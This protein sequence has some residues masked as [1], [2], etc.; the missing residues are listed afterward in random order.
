MRKS[1]FWK[2]FV[3]LQPLQPL[4]LVETRVEA[5]FSQS[6]Y[7]VE[8]LAY[9]IVRC[10]APLK[11]TFYSLASRGCRGSFPNSSQEQRFP[12]SWEL[13]D[14]YDEEDYDGW[15]SDEEWLDLM[16]DEEEEI[17]SWQQ[18]AVDEAID[19]EKPGQYPAN[20]NTSIGDIPF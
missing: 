19:D 13:G 2:R 16:D 14:E 18:R 15:L 7:R 5:L 1:P 8:A 3:P 17:K 6:R 12:D 4:L 20:N 11:P 9:L 10:I